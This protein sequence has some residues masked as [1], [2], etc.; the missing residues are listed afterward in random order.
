MKNSVLLFV[1]IALGVV[2]ILLFGLAEINKYRSDTRSRD[3]GA[4]SKDFDR[5]ENRERV[6]G[7]LS[8]I[9]LVSMLCI[10]LCLIF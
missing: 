9:S 2:S 3:D 4:T 10:F 7:G 8:C 6:F 1:F 5:W